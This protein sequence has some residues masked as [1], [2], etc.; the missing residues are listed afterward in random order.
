MLRADVVEGFQKAG[1]P[2]RYKAGEPVVLANEPSTGMY[3]IL[4]GEVRVIIRDAQG[5][6]IT[7]ATM[8]AGQTM[9]EISLLLDQP[10]S[11]TVIAQTEVEALLLT[12]SRLRDLREADPQ[13]A[14]Q[15]YEI[16]AFTLASHIMDQNRTLAGLRRELDLVQKRLDERKEVFSYF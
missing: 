15:L 6:E 14:M 1:I 5:Q 13:L 8:H 10:H 11:A 4:K 3:L 9:G 12:Q 16:L 2:R 7:V